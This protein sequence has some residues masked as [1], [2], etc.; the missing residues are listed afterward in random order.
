MP[1]PRLTS[2]PLACPTPPD[3]L[4]RG[5]V[6]DAAAICPIC[7]A[8]FITYR[9]A[10]DPAKRPLVHSSLSE[11][12]TTCGKLTCEDAEQL[13][14]LRPRMAEARARMD[15]AKKQREAEEAAKAERAKN[16]KLKKIGDL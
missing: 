5:L 4:A 7:R 1:A 3:A 6:K 9:R 2:R 15:A 11:I 8:R 10:D 14:I 16:L 12:R 13:R